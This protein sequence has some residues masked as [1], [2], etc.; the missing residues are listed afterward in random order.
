MCDPPFRLTALFLPPETPSPWLDQIRGIHEIP[1]TNSNNI[2]LSLNAL[3][4]CNQ[5]DGIV[6]E[7]PS[8]QGIYN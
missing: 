8:Q 2:S 6:F 4:F 3:P 1:Q 5:F 7:T